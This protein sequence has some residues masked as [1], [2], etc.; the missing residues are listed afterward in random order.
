VISP[1]EFNDPAA[2][3]YCTV[4][5]FIVA[6]DVGLL[7]KHSDHRSM[8]SDKGCPG[9][10]KPPAKRTPKEVASLAFT[11]TKGGDN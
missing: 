4:C 6:V 8:L 11:Y 10:D 9:S 1:A 2:W 3:G 5:K 7:W